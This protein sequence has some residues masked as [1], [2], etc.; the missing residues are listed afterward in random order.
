M[1]T[2]NVSNLFQ[3]SVAAGAM[4]PK[5]KDVLN[6][7]D[8]GPAIQQGMGIVADDVPASEVILVSLLL[9][10]SGSISMAN[11]EQVIRDGVNTIIDSLRKSKQDDN[12]LVKIQYLNGTLLCP[13]LPLKDVPLLDGQNFR[14]TGQTPLYDQ[15]A[16]VLAGVFAKTQEFANNGTPVR[17]VTMVVTDGADYGSR[18]HTP[19]TVK[20]LVEDLYM[21]ESHI[22]AGMGIDDHGHTDFSQVFKSMGVRD[23]WIL[24][25]SNSPSEIRKAFQVVSQSVTKVSQNAAAFSQGK[26]G[27]FGS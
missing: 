17:S 9:D 20:V 22:I 21:Q 2:Q 8:M 15:T 18:K 7:P 12:I 25:P 1:S 24:T 10:D 11:N 27:G 13:Y 14:A 23:A 4:S 26:L 6:I 19:D 5:S 3:Q 16:L